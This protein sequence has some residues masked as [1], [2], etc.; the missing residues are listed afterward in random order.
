M[1][2][3][4]NEFPIIYV[5]SPGTLLEELTPE[6][7]VIFSFFTST[8]GI[9]VLIVHGNERGIFPKVSEEAIL[10]CNPDRIYCCYPKSCRWTT[11]DERII[12]AHDSPTGYK[13]SE[14]GEGQ[15]LFTL[16][17]HDE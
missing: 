8:D 3:V 12:G 11:A 13:R 15:V 9:K 16:E 14:I 6:G 1:Q 17:I 4:H 7:G 2:S 10:E 5:S